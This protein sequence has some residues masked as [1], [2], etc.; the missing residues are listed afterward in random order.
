MENRWGD[1]G[2]GQSDGP[3]ERSVVSICIPLVLTII[4]IVLMI[5]A[6]QDGDDVGQMPLFWVGL[7][8][9]L[10]LPVCAV[11]GGILFCSFAWCTS[12]IIVFFYKP[13]KP[14]DSPPV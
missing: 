14:Q 6:S 7:G 5:I 8:L 4:G 3:P 11:I 1:G 10:C 12:C 9:V 2:I 13:E